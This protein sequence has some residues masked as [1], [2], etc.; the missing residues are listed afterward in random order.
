VASARRGSEFSLIRADRGDDF[1]VVNNVGGGLT[2]P[3]FAFSAN[4]RHFGTFSCPPNFPSA[5][6]PVLDYTGFRAQAS[7]GVLVLAS[8]GLA[9]NAVA[10]IAFQA[11]D[12]TLVD[13][14]PVINNVYDVSSTPQQPVKG[15][16]AL[17]ASGHVIWSR[18]FIPVSA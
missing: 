5:A 8:R 4:N 17:D 16:E 11:L 18:R 14:T 3:C 13:K 7:G 1:Y 6:V 15:I 12:G 10:D 9:V 2:R